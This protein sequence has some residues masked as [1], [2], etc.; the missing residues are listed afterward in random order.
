MARAQGQQHVVQPNTFALQLPHEAAYSRHEASLA[1]FQA[2]SWCSGVSMRC[3]W[4][5]LSGR[6]T[7]VPGR[8]RLRLCGT[9]ESMQ[10]CGAARA[11]AHAPGRC[12]KPACMTHCCQLDVLIVLRSALCRWSLCSS[13]CCRRSVLAATCPSPPSRSG[14]QPTPNQPPAQHDTNKPKPLLTY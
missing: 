3:C 7:R 11:L 12:V 13:S 2:V 5:G 9:F 8:P 4:L 14:A 10:W 6:L 1:A